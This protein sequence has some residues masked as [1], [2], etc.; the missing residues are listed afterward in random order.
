MN[1]DFLSGVTK[2]MVTGTSVTGSKDALRLS[3]L[4]PGSLYCTAGKPIFRAM[5]SSHCKYLSYK[6]IIAKDIS[7]VIFQALS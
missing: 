4:Y 6:E 1:H 2:I 7:Y 3:R 5:V